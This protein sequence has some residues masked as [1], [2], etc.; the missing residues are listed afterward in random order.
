MTGKE[1]YL[2]GKRI[3]VYLQDAKFKGI[4]MSYVDGWG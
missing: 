3:P 1:S 4:N 2:N